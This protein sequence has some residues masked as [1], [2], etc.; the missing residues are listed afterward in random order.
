MKK[1]MFIIMV[2]VNSYY[3]V[4]GQVV[5]VDTPEYIGSE[6]IEDNKNELCYP[7]CKVKLTDGQSLVGNVINENENEIELK[8]LS[9]S[10]LKLN[11]ESVVRIVEYRDAKLAGNGKLWV[12]DPIRT[13]YF[14]SPSAMM[15]EKGEVSFSQ[16]ELLLSMVNVGLTDWATLYLGSI[17]PAWF[18]GPGLMAC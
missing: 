9:G 5:G 7:Y 10:V 16:K 2:L 6:E 12:Q 11:A 13:G 4:D 8:L 3:N 14:V 17:I 15:L 1:I 18:W